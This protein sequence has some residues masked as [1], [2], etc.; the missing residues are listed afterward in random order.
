MCVWCVGQGMVPTTNV[1]ID[2]KLGIALNAIL[3]NG[4]DW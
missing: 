1:K 2:W 3:I 4:W